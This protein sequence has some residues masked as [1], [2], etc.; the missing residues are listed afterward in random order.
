M[1]VYTSIKGVL[2]HCA[3]SNCSLISDLLSPW[4]QLSGLVLMDCEGHLPIVQWPLLNNLYRYPTIKVLNTHIY[5]ELAKS[6]RAGDRKWSREKERERE[7]VVAK[8]N[9]REPMH[10]NG[11]QLTWHVKEQEKHTHTHTHSSSDERGGLTDGPIETHHWLRTMTGPLAI[12]HT[13]TH[14]QV[15]MLAANNIANME[16]RCFI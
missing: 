8:I 14:N 9:T 2:C 16:K 12:Q 4:E 1:Y 3:F 6:R 5:T 7:T 15:C 11:A 13:H 10:H